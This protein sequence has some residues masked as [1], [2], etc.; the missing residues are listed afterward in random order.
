MILKIFRI[1]E[2]VAGGKVPKIV[3][4]IFSAVTSI[5]ILSLF[6]RFMAHVMLN[7]PEFRG[8]GIPLE[9]LMKTKYFGSLKIDEDPSKRMLKVIGDV[10]LEV[11]NN[12]SQ[13]KLIAVESE[14]I[15]YKTSPDIDKIDTIQVEIHP[16]SWDVSG[17]KTY[18]A[19]VSNIKKRLGG[20]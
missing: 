9:A 20:K 12:E 19:T 4:V 13:C 14:N 17:Q 18:T 6:A 16:R 3:R 7:Q 11:Y 2:S 10:P 5:L 15:T 8:T 1:R